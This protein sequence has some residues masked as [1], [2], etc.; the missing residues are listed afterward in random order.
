MLHVYMYNYIPTINLEIFIAK[1][2]L[3]SMAAINI[4][5]MKRHAYY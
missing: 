2:F 3:K 5:L 1:I 4:N